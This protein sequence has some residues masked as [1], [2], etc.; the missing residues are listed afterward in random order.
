MKI[1][2]IVT[3]LHASDVQQLKTR[4]EEW[5]R[6]LFGLQLNA[7]TSPVK[8][9]SQFSLLRKNIARGLTIIRQKQGSGWKKS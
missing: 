7:V 9:I 1:A 6:E 3:E 5:R 4:V 2:K 8:D